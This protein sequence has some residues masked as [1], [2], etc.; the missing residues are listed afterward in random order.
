MMLIFNR[1][2]KLI[3]IKG[4]RGICWEVAM[5]MTRQDCFSSHMG[6]RYRC[7]GRDARPDRS[8][9]AIAGCIGMMKLS[10]RFPYHQGV[11][12]Q[13]LVA[14][15]PSHTGPTGPDHDYRRGKPSSI[16]NKQRTRLEVSS[17][18]MMH[19]LMNCNS[20]HSFYR[21][22]F[23]SVISACKCYIRSLGRFPNG[24]SEAWLA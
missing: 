16:V 23:G 12:H 15:R 14:N 3:E 7:H 22:S 2:K 24:L 19:V 17:K 5:Q 8:L 6:E 1:I 21:Y 10:V 9:H 11:P 20:I 4:V 13:C 18:S